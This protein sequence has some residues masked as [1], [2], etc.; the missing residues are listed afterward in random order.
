MKQGTIET[1]G[2]CKSKWYCVQAV[3][4]EKR[5]EWNASEQVPTFYLSADVQGITSEEH[6]SKIAQDILGPD[7]AFAIFPFAP[8][9]YQLQLEVGDTLA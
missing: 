3:R 4:K 2:F 1:D 9:L 8:A 5:G 7:C 6:A